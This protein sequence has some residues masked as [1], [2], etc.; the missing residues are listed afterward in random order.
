MTVI[1]LYSV[2]TT[3]DSNTWKQ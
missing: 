3:G 1:Y 2:G